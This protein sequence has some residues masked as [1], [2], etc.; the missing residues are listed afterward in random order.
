MLFFCYY[1]WEALQL[2]LICYVINLCQQQDINR[3]FVEYKG[4]EFCQVLSEFL[5]YIFNQ[6]IMKLRDH[7]SCKLRMMTR[8]DSKKTSKKLYARALVSKVSL[9]Q[10][11]NLPSVTVLTLPFVIQHSYSLIQLTLCMEQVCLHYK[12]GK[13]KTNP[14]THSL[15]CRFCCVLNCQPITLVK[16][17]KMMLEHLSC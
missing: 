14:P 16:C 3:N 1:V 8:K 11:I 17:A 2:L 6:Q 4:K 12:D 9:P 15:N 13:R 10:F 7:C 5:L